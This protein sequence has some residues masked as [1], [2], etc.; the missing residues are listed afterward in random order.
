[1]YL[2]LVM[3]DMQLVVK[4]HQ[5]HSSCCIRLHQCQC[6]SGALLQRARGR[7][8][9]GASQLA[10]FEGLQAAVLCSRHQLG[11]DSSS[12]GDGSSCDIVSSIAWPLLLL[13][14]LAGSRVM[15]G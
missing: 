4:I 13:L 3:S 14:L 5:R 1:V 8:H 12:I 10:A 9:H 15:H 2:L 7:R 6:F 11:T